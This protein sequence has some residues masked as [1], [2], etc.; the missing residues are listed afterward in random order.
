MSP[1]VLIGIGAVSTTVVIVAAWLML[2]MSDGDIQLAARLDAA[3][4]A[5]M[6]RPVPAPR[7]PC[8]FCRQPSAP[9][10]AG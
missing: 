4:G 8:S 1:M 9:L 2:R 5:A 3:R 6:C 7:T 10:A